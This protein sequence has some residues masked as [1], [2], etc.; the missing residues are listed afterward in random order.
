MRTMMYLGHFYYINWLKF[1]MNHL[2][3]VKTFCG[4]R[5]QAKKIIN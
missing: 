4:N 1:Y 5:S 2:I 3:S